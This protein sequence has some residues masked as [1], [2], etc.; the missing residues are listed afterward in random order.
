M[1][2]VVPT[3]NKLAHLVP[4]CVRRLNTYWPGND[5]WVLHFDEKPDVECNTYFMGEQGLA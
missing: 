2:I 4:E 1:K 5:I 3:C